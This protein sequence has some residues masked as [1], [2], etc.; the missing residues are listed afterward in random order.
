MFCSGHLHWVQGLTGISLCSC[1]AHKAPVF[2]S[3]SLATNPLQI[4]VTETGKQTQVKEHSCILWSVLLG[5]N[6]ICT[7]I[8]V[9]SEKKTSIICM[10]RS[11]F[12]NQYL[13]KAIFVWSAHGNHNFFFCSELVLSQRDW[14]DF[15]IFFYLEAAFASSGFCQFFT[16]ISS[17]TSFKTCLWFWSSF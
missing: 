13:F 14:T 16:F 12:Q 6:L 2:Q 4:K 1:P 8:N 10:H 3:D 7:Q 15:L 17:M 11:L 9:F 5:I